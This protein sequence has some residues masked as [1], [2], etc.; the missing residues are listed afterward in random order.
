[1]IPSPSEDVQLILL[2]QRRQ[3][4]RLY[5]WALFPMLLFFMAFGYQFWKVPPHEVLGRMHIYP[6]ARIAFSKMMPSKEL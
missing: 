6:R 2:Q 5:F 1:M 3:R 4:R